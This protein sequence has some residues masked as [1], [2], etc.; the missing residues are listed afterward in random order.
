MHITGENMVNSY[1]CI[2]LVVFYAYSWWNQGNSYA[3]IH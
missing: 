2:H 1:A 3:W